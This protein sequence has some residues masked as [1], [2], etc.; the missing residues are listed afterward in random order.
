MKPYTEWEDYK[1]GMY[2]CHPSSDESAVMDAV[3]LLRD[4]NRLTAAM[5]SVTV[6]WVNACEVNLSQP[7]NNR[8]W[9]GQAACCIVLGTPEHLTRTAWG[10]LT[11]D[12]RLVANA[13][14][15]RVIDQWIRGVKQ[16]VQLEFSFDA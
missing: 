15:D 2:S 7:P 12:E 3:L 6:Q 5:R 8:S 4:R 14:A 9:L 1:A 13:I 10:R 11:D 16:I